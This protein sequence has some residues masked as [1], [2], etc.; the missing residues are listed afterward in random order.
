MKWANMVMNSTA[1]VGERTV[2]LNQVRGYGE[3]YAPEDLYSNVGATIVREGSY[4]FAMMAPRIPSTA[5][6][7]RANAFRYTSSL[8]EENLK[9]DG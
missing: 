4:L 6:T 5:W 3:M 8:R 2:T 1:M 7:T 9:S